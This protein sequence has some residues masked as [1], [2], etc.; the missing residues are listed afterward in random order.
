MFAG[1]VGLSLLSLTAPLWAVSLLM[2]PVGVGGSLTV[3]PLTALIMNGAPAE[4]AGMT[5]GVLNASRQMG[6]SLGVA[7]FGAVLA[8]QASFIDGARLDYRATALLL[9]LVGGLVLRLRGSA[10]LTAA[11]TTND[12]QMVLD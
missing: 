10:P 6:G 9:R 11:P 8:T 1:L 7:V 5:S 12:R 3:P 2:V 4:R